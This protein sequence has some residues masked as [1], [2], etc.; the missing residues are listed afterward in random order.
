MNAQHIMF[1]KPHVVELVDFE[2]DMSALA[3]NEVAIQN[4]YS[5]I[6]PGTELACLSGIESWA[7]LP[8]VPGYASCGEVIAVGEAVTH[9]RS[10]EMVLC[11][12]KHASHVIV[13]R[14]VMPLPP[15]IEAQRAPFAR[16]AAVSITALRVGQPELGDFAAVTGLG[17]VGNL[18][19]QLLGLAGCEVI[20]LDIEP[21]RLELAA[22]CG[23]PHLINSA[24]EDPAAA[25]ERIT[26]GRKCELVVEATGLSPVA[27]WAVDLAGTL[28]QVVLLGSPRDAY[29]TDLTPLLRKIHLWNSGCIT[30]KGAHE[31]RYPAARDAHGA[32]RHSIERNLEIL[33]RLLAQE[34][35]LV[36][37]LVTHVLPPA[38]CAQAYAGLRD[39]PDRYV[40]VLFGWTEG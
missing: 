26:A 4:H 17:L 7:P 8:F 9:V 23:I 27:E 37:P 35:L 40:G 14:L 18:C 12:G 15:G 22:D 28:G 24:S 2:F 30:L 29:E 19:G 34:R 21:A 38:D 1:T 5:L 36:D 31:W 13:N 11:Y 39:E 25:V 6:S 10:G 16:M 32:A 3:P 33:L 20:G